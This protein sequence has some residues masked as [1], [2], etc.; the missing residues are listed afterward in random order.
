MIVQGANGAELRHCSGMAYDLVTIYASVSDINGRFIGGLNRKTLRS[1]TTALARRSSISARKNA[2]SQSVLSLIPRQAWSRIAHAID[3]LDH[4]LQLQHNDDQ[5]LL[6]FNTTVNMAQNYTQ[7]QANIINSLNDV[8]PSGLTA[9]N[10][11]IYAGV[12]KLKQG[13]YTKRALLVI[14]DGQDN[15]SWYHSKDLSNILR[16]SDV[17]IFTVGITDESKLADNS[18]SE[19]RPRATE[20]V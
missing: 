17:Q 5:F 18:L 9:L 1:M 14:S 7:F 15:S 12:E 11:A 10:D 20:T 19:R 2:P 8:T 16:E 13:R 6:T 3:A 4:F